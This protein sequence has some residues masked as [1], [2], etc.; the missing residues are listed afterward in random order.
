ML[1]SV[2]ASIIVKWKVRLSTALSRQANR[3][4]KKRQKWLLCIYCGIF[5]AGLTGNFW[6]L[7]KNMAGSMPAQSYQASHIGMPSNMPLPKQPFKTT[8]S[9]IIKK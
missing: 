6:G 1:A 3:Y 4:T 7:K 8:D 5:I 9:L 2:I